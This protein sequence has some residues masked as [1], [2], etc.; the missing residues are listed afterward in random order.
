MNIPSSTLRQRRWLIIATLALFAGGTTWLAAEAK[1]DDKQPVNIK[2][3]P[4]PLPRAQD[5]SLSLSPIVKRVTPSVVKVVT[6]ERAKE[7]EVGGG[8][9][10]DDPDLRQFFGPFFGGRGGQRRIVRQPPQIGLG[11]GVIVSADGYIL[12]NN[13]VVDDAD[14][15]KVTLSDGR[16]LT[17]K[18]VGKDQKSDIAV[19]KVDARD[20]PALTFADSDDIQVGDRVHFGAHAL[21]HL[22]RGALAGG[23]AGRRDA[24]EVAKVA[25]V[26][27]ALRVDRDGH[28]HGGKRH[29]AG[30]VLGVVRAVRA[31]AP[32][33]Q[34]RRRLRRP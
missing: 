32:G 1:H 5:S 21:G 4:A 23:H 9:P 17:A 12:T 8:M 20:L 6:R 29:L 33:R 34:D 19:I 26:G 28:V 31:G 11:S 13:H 18:V 16:I 22:R 10:F 3:D 24:P 14:R 30:L 25:V 15:L 27:D 2:V 7:M